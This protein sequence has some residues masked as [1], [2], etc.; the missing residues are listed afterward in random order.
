MIK[1]SLKTMTVVC[2][3]NVGLNLIF[4]FCTPLS[5]RGIALATVTA[6]FVGCLINLRLT[7]RVIKG[8]RALSRDVVRR[9]GQI[10]WPMG[11][12]QVLW[13]LGSMALFL[14]LSELP[15]N[16]V[17][18]I[19]AFT[20]GLRI[21]SA[22]YLPAFAFNMA[23]AVIVGNLLGAKKQEEAYRSGL[24]TALVGVSVVVALVVIV[25]VNARW[26]T[27]LL[28]TN[29]I[30]VRECMRYI[31]I[32][33]ISEPFMAW[34]I[35]LGG[36][37]AGAGD[38]RSVMIRVALSIWLVRIPLAYL[39]VKVLGFGAASVWWSMNISQFVQSFFLY[40]RYSKKDWLAAAGA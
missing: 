37:L 20:A 17:E 19:A 7:S 29:P 22:I 3:L 8:I 25:I 32:A 28:S 4:V 40:R 6:V 31:Y 33:L 13:Q 24:T 27:S 18:I 14:V 15:E 21:E 39:F 1:D 38:T 11:A 5:Y 30:V 23:N 12:L 2:C 10:G 16:R 34:G 35:I 36:G 9:I 26:I